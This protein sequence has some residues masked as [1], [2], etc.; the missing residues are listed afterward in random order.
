MTLPKNLSAHDDLELALKLLKFD[1]GEQVSDISKAY[2]EKYKNA[3]K[4][5]KPSQETQQFL[6]DLEKYPQGF[7]NAIPSRWV[8]T[9]PKPVAKAESAAVQNQVSWSNAGPT[10]DTTNGKAEGD[11]MEKHTK[12]QYYFW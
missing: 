12:D 1:N 8:E 10:S 4:G 11:L 2:I 9:G 5:E 7:S 3:Q 6:K